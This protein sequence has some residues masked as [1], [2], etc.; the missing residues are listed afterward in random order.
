MWT[1]L[2][3]ASA[4]LRSPRGPAST[5]PTSRR[6]SPT[7]SGSHPTWTSAAWT[8]LQGASG[9]GAQAT[10]TH[11]LSSHSISATTQAQGLSNVKIPLYL[12]VT[13]HWEQWGGILPQSLDL[14][15]CINMIHISPLKCTEGLFRAAGHLLKPKA[16][17]IT[18]GPYAVNG[19]ISPQ[20]NVDFDLTL[21]CRNPEWGLR[22]TALLQDLGQASGLLLERTVDMPANNK[23]L[24]FRKE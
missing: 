12:D 15:L 2:S 14:L 8:G 17:L 6:R 7:P 23:C 13:W 18:Y 24:I 1:R 3:A 16:L 9:T 19:K 21:R 20:S 22:D 5:Q 10:P 11:R 4:C